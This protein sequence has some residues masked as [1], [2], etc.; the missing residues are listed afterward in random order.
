MLDIHQ[1]PV[2]N[3]NYVYLI[4]E[5]E[6]G[7]TAV[8]DPAVAAPVLAEA[9]RLGWTITHILNTHHH[10]D[11]VGG[12]LE[13]QAATG[14]HIVGPRADRDRIP[15]IQTEVGDGDHVNFGQ[16][17]ATVFDVPGHTRG[18][19]AYWFEQDNALFCGDTLFA[20]GCGRL[21][22]GTPAQMWHSL[23]KLKA[24]PDETQ[25]YCA[26][27]Y[28]Q[29]NAKFALSVD[30]SNVALI[31]RAAEIDAARARGKPTVPSTLGQEKQTNPFLRADNGVLAR[32]IGLAGAAAVDVFAEV[33]AR[34]DHF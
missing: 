24:L 15:G 14:C 31:Q 21:F 27:E 29:A 19:I 16:A 20:L 10:G 18:H 23:G 13:I 34:K 9:K 3:D 2:L 8:V 32:N 30:G 12:N 11:H 4:R 33:R 22:E 28:T 1:I 17:V 5:T 26:H 6:S 7:V 25:V